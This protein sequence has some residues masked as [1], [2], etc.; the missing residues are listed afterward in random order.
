MYKVARKL[1]EHFC[2]F[3]DCGEIILLKLQ[4]IT[5][6]YHSNVAFS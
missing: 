2:F 6:F 1:H 3:G 5:Y 4:P